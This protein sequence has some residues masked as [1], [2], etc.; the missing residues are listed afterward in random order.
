[1]NEKPFARLLVSHLAAQ[2]LLRQSL[3]A[4]SAWL[5]EDTLLTRTPHPQVNGARLMKEGKFEKLDGSSNPTYRVTYRGRKYFVKTMDKES[6]VH[7]L[8]ARKIADAAG[9]SGFIPHAQGVQHGGQD[10]LIM[11]W[12][13]EKTPKDGAELGPVY[14]HQKT[15]LA[16]LEHL[17]GGEK[18]TSGDYFV[19]EDGLHLQGVDWQIGTKAGHQSTPLSE[20]LGKDALLP[21]LVLN[22][23]AAKASKIEAAAKDL[24]PEEQAAIHDRLEHLKQ[25]SK[26]NA[27]H[28]LADL[29]V[30][31][32]E[33]TA[34][35]K[36]ALGAFDVGPMDAAE[37]SKINEKLMNDV[38][39][40]DSI[41]EG[42]GQTKARIAKTLAARLKDNP[43][44]MDHLDE[45]KQAWGD[46][47][48]YQYQT[49]DT[50]T[51]V[52]NRIVAQW[53]E[54]STD[55]NAR[56]IALQLAA[57]KEF[58][59]ED[60]AHWWGK[61]T[62]EQAKA[63]MGH[64][65]EGNRAVLRAMYDNTQEFFKSKGITSL[66][67]VRGAA[68]DDNVPQYKATGKIE[69]AAETHLQPFSAFTLNIGTAMG[70]FTGNHMGYGG[71]KHK[72]AF[73]ARVPVSRILASCQTGFGCKG[74]TEVLILG[75][76]VKTHHYSWNTHNPTPDEGWKILEQASKDET[77]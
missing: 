73:A 1:M 48:Y 43:A 41:K 24:S 61:E 57:E 69:H 36:D 62:D 22:K 75:G 74:E 17:T 35:P 5:D 38:L 45:L 33:G 55:H 20:H 71:S 54:C 52:C 4:L 12:K 8:A 49:G 65:E 3:D 37:Q 27:D 40:K 14:M 10:H 21:N 47:T 26:D 42:A 23:V 63:T 76:R 59:L 56:A 16:L 11:A 46:S 15:Q 64:V 51:D 9:M 34:A 31:K 39:D 53:K 32:K 13:N 58:G 70:Q 60:A 6:A 50:A 18:R 28:T 44:F 30:G 68:W 72:H 67:V 7:E 77:S 29:G 66:Y 25:L 19:S 2:R